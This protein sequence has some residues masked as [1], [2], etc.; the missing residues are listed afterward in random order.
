MSLSPNIKEDIEIDEEEEKGTEVEILL[1]KNAY[2][3]ITNLYEM[4][5]ITLEKAKKTEESK[6][7]AIKQASEKQERVAKEKKIQLVDV[8]KMRKRF[9]FEKFHWFISSEN[10]IIISGKDAL[11]NDVM[12]RRYMKDN[13]IYVHAAP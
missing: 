9:W 10:F 3:N 6:E 5:K 13:D 4:R 11:Q 12:Y 1:T 7:I 2:E 8:K